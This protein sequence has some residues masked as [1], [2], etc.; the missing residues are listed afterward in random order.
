EYDIQRVFELV[1]S[2]SCCQGCY[3]ASTGRVYQGVGWSRGDGQRR[4]L[5]L[6]TMQN[7]PPSRQA[8]NVFANASSVNYS[9]EMILA[10]RSIHRQTRNTRRV[11][12]QRSRLNKLY[13]P[14]LDGQHGQ[15]RTGEVFSTG[16]ES[17]DPA[18]Q[19]RTVRRH[20][21]FGELEQWTLH[22]V[23]Q[24]ARKVDVLRR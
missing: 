23:C 15:G 21:P 22:R 13:A 18:V 3:Q 6:S 14:T 24:V 10:Q 16:P 9:P 19:V 12:A 1:G 8:T 11:S 2:D 17:A 5:A 20:E 4:C 7:S